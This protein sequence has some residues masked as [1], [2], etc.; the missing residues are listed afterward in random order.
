MCDSKLRV[1]KMLV[2]KALATLMNASPIVEV[3]AVM[4]FLARRPLITSGLRLSL[5]LSGQYRLEDSKPIACSCILH[6]GTA[7]T[8]CF[9]SK[10]TD[11]NIETFP[12]I[13]KLY[14]PSLIDSA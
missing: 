10:N 3:V 4:A 11:K 6:A 12:C 7:G 1:Q 8:P 9:A 5:L 13:L 2:S 14:V